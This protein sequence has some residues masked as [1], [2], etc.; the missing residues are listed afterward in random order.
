[1]D[2]LSD[3]AWTVWATVAVLLAL[4]EMVSLDFVLVMLAAGAGAGA[5]SSLVSPSVWID[6]LV[7]AAVAVGMLAVVRPSLVRRMHGGPELTTGH[8]ALVGRKGVAVEPV[9]DHHGRIKLAGEMWSA[10]VFDPGTRIEAGAEV[11]VFGIDGATA[12][13][14]PLD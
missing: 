1:M 11:E 14:Y 8:A 10:R 12:V 3:H 5:V 9:D 4:A 2:W 7:A 13:V 6:L